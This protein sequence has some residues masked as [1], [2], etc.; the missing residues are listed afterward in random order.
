[1]A[2]ITKE[3]NRLVRRDG[4]ELL[5]I[6]PWGAN[7]LRVRATRLAAMP[8]DD[9]A[10]LPAAEGEAAITIDEPRASITCGG[11]TARIN[12]E[13]WLT[14]ENARG[15]LLLSE[16][17]RNRDDITRY[18]VPLKLSA[19][20]MKARMGSDD[21]A[22]T[23]RFEA[24]DDE[25]I[26]GMGQY[27]DSQLNKKGCTLELAHRN[28]QASVPFYVSSLGY[29]FLWNNPG[30]GQVTFATNRTEWTLASTRSLDYW[31]TAGDTPAQIESQYADAT[32][33]VP[34]MPEYGLGFWQCKLRYRTQEELLSVAREH[35]RRGLPMDVIVVDFFHWTM[36]GD[37][38][39]DPVDWPDPEGMV[40]ELKSMGIE[41]MVS[42]WPTVDARSENYKKLNERGLLIGVDRGSP[43]NMNW[44]GETLF[45]D[46]TNPEAQRFV[47]DVVKKNYFDKG[48]RIFWLDEAEP[49]GIYDFDLYRFHRGPALQVSNLYP[50]GFAQGFYDGMKEAG[51]DPVMNLIRC[52]W[53]GGQRY[54]ALAW[55]GDVYSSFRTLRE[56][57]QAG[58]SMAMAGIPWWTTDIGG[59]IGADIHSPTFHELIV[60]W[61]QWGAFCPVMRLH[62]ERPPFKPL[63]DNEWREGVRQFSSGQDNEV[64]SY[65]ED[66]YAILEQYLMLRER[67]RPYMRSLMAA[68][69]ESGAPVMRPL[70]YDFPGEAALWDVADQYMLGPDILVAPVMEEG[71]RSRSVVLPAGVH[72]RNARTGEVIPGG[73]T[74]TVPAPLDT[75]P[76]FV[77]EGS[78]VKVW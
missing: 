67:L 18:S 6:E 65:G 66:V 37:W 50:N 51:V 61:F 71:V 39:F 28:S 16:Y 24:R 22:L 45:Y 58:L 29:G 78:D 5:W 52:I 54:G 7:S 21:Y 2:I 72:W 59:F 11:L 69:H 70:F 23:A 35:K 56:Q 36:Q 1:M 13:G 30:V 46:A 38:Q 20:E 27:Q 44:M 77:R 75:I 40:A 60:R 57:L 19:R 42:I 12:N 48:I 26:F 76:V 10:L 32:G 31:V 4:R 14:F 15:E 8:E 34:M 3:G 63:G 74:I 47:W 41:L 33:H 62:G 17:W 55:S 43:I 49:E 64:W 68:A 53:A 9:W 25:K 73:Q